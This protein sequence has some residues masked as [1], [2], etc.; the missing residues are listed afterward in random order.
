MASK[1]RLMLRGVSLVSIV[2]YQCKR[3]AGVETMRKRLATFLFA[4]VFVLV[5]G[6]AACG[7][8]GGE[9]EEQAEQEEPKEETTEAQQVEEEKVVVKEEE[10]VKV[11]GTG[12]SWEE[13]PEEVK[14]QMPEE[15]KQKI[16]AQ[17]QQ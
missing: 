5:F 16:K 4:A 6:T 14:E 7:G 11:E 8:G 10:T 9:E 1:G 2:P 12:P 17:Q 15:V 13:L 3:P